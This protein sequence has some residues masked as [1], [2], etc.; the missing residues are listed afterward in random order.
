[1]IDYKAWEERIWQYFD[2]HLA[3][4]E[5]EAL[6]QSLEKND[7]LLAIFESCQ[8]LHSMLQQDKADQPSPSFV[9]GVKAKI[10]STSLGTS[11]QSDWKKAGWVFLAAAS[12]ILLISIY[13]VVNGPE[14][15]TSQYPVL[16]DFVYNLTEYSFFRNLAWLS[17]G[18]FLLMMIDQVIIG[19]RKRQR[20]IKPV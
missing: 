10:N 6:L 16:T 11:G 18:L 15:G 9:S 2:G 14:S 19:T 17:S 20:S 5:K 8:S 3:E 12:V 13:L 7:E 4:S 1:M